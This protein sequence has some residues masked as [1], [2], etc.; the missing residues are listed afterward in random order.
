MLYS[1]LQKL[2]TRKRTMLQE[3]ISGRKYDLIHQNPSQLNKLLFPV[4]DEHLERYKFAG[5]LIGEAKDTTVLDAASGCGWGTKY[6][7]D[8]TKAKTVIGVDCSDEAVAESRQGAENQEN[9]SFIKA[10]LLDRLAV[11]SYSG[12]D[13]IVSFETL[14]HFSLT[15]SATFLANLRAAHT[16]KGKL[17]VSS[18][19]HPLFSPYAT[20]EGGPWF[21]AHFHEYSEEELLDQLEKSGWKVMDFYGQRFVDPKQHLEIAKRLY[22]LKLAGKLLKLPSDHR[23]SHLPLWLL[24][25]VAASQSSGKVANFPSGKKP[26]CLIAVCE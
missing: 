2:E 3:R 10:D 14:E 25:R 4:W 13:W 24:H 26:L 12:A 1:I 9:V 16:G 11:R 8:K 21:R 7:A 6:L 20:L 23:L 5:Q 22:P 19:N 15:D 17:I 18:P